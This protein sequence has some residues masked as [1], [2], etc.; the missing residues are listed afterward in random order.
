MTSADVALADFKDDEEVHKKL[1]QS[2]A[3][4]YFSPRG[5]YPVEVPNGTAPCWPHL[6]T[7]HLD[8]ST[9]AHSEFKEHFSELDKDENSLLQAWLHASNHILPPSL[10]KQYL[11]CMR[12][13]ESLASKRFNTHALHIYPGVFAIDKKMFVGDTVFALSKTSGYNLASNYEFTKN[14]KL[15]D[16]VIKYDSLTPVSPDTFDDSAP[17]T[18]KRKV[19]PSAEVAKSERWKNTPAI[20]CLFAIAVEDVQ[21]LE[22]GKTFRKRTPMII[23]ENY[24][25]KEAGQQDSS[26]E[27]VVAARPYHTT[28]RVFEL[29]LESSALLFACLR[30]QLAVTDAAPSPPWSENTMALSQQSP[31]IRLTRVHP[32]ISALL[33]CLQ[34]EFARVIVTKKEEVISSELWDL[35]TSDVDPSKK[36]LCVLHVASAVRFAEHRASKPSALKYVPTTERQKL[37]LV[38]LK[39][40]RRLAATMWDIL[41]GKDSLTEQEA[42]EH[43]RNIVKNWN[44]LGYGILKLPHHERRLG[45]LRGICS[46]PGSPYLLPQVDDPLLSYTRTVGTFFEKLKNLTEGGFCHDPLSADRDPLNVYAARFLFHKDKGVFDM[47]ENII[48]AVEEDPDENLSNVTSDDED[49]D[50]DDY[51][52]DQSESESDSYDENQDEGESESEGGSENMEGEPGEDEAREA[53]KLSK[54]AKKRV[55]SRNGNVLQ[56]G[57]RSERNGA[58]VHTKRTEPMKQ[59]EDPTPLKEANQSDTESEDQDYKQQEETK[60]SS[61]ESSAESSDES[62]DQDHDVKHNKRRKSAS[63]ASTSSKRTRVSQDKTE[64]SSAELGYALHAALTAI[65]EMHDMLEA[66]LPIASASAIGVVSDPNSVK[67]S[68][69][70]QEAIATK[71]ASIKQ[72]LATAHPTIK[73]PLVTE[74]KSIYKVA[75]E[76]CSVVRLTLE[77]LKGHLAITEK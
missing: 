27:S 57:A 16:A 65:G 24:G 61:D 3:T 74:K 12:N 77:Q 42:I 26:L 68:A 9:T 56:R 50:E 64:S 67:T 4:I 70:P 38:D 63:R 14:S 55:D 62:F 59:G 43:E 23:M 22:V 47:R 6:R 8:N 41:S 31:A 52:D 48:T 29:T 75:V 53:K 5:L 13:E 46:Q 40:R 36:S 15:L 37:D 21:S 66:A 58:T 18:Q 72:L 1:A 76:I 25:Y 20:P 30:E 73:Q 33:I 17:S 39:A 54:A 7:I 11:E 2:K 51:E 34:Y 71:I 32:S 49:E 60:R 45:Q 35:S 10:P 19:A 28:T 44:H 69:G